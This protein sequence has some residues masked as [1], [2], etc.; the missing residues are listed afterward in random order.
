M[1]DLDPA[2][3]AICRLPALLAGAG[4]IIGEAFFLMQ[5]EGRDPLPG[6]PAQ[7]L[8]RD[9]EGSQTRYAVAL[10]FLDGFGPD[11]GAT[12]LV[13]GS[14]LSAEPGI[15]AVVVISGQAGDV[16]LLDANLLHGA[17]SN[18]SGAPRRSFLA[19]YA[20]ADLRESLRAS[21]AYARAGGHALLIR[22]PVAMRATIPALHPAAPGVARVERA[23]RA[24][25]DPAGVFETGRFLD[26]PRAD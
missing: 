11:N 4:L 9:A 12:A 19:S 7:S 3:Q 17:T 22:A 15:S 10:I 24:A 18:T 25:F 2:V 23:V 13:P 5:V 16:V 26:I 20:A 1:V 6:N 14:H 8:H 21:V